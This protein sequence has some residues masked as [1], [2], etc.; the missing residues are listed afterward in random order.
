MY[1]LDAPP[2]PLDA[3][4]V[5]APPPPPADAIPPPPSSSGC[6]PPPCQKID[7]QQAVG[8]HPT[9]MHTCIIFGNRSTLVLFALIP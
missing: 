8:M 9:G 2:P 6:T 5:D 1:P 3:P 7:G 4:P